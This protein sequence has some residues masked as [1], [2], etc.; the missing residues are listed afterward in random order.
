M[1]ENYLDKVT[2]RRMEQVA[3]CVITAMKRGRSEE[4]I[5]VKVEKI[6]RACAE[7]MRLSGYHF[8]QEV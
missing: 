2:L 5:R 3:R 4:A 7:L 1:I 8:D 6:V